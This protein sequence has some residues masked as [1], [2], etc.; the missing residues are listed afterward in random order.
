MQ[1]CQVLSSVSSSAQMQVLDRA[2]SVCRSRRTIQSLKK[3]QCHQRHYLKRPNA[4]AC[5]RQSS[6]NCR[7]GYQ[8]I[9][10]RVRMTHKKGPHRPRRESTSPCQCLRLRP[11]AISGRHVLSH[12]PV[13]R[14][15]QHMGTAVPTGV[16]PRVGTVPRR[17][18]VWH[19]LFGAGGRATLMD[20][21]RRWGQ[22]QGTLHNVFSWQTRTQSRTLRTCGLLQQ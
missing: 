10:R 5:M 3:A 4:G 7:D 1:Y 19:C 13:E 18:R 16:V 21:S 11:V 22:Q 14:T 12:A 15:G 8:A 17:E 6:K 2:L 9:S 20:L